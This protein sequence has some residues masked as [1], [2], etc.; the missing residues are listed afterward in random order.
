MIRITPEPGWTAGPYELYASSAQVKKEWDDLVATR[1]ND[2]KRCFERLTSAPLDRYPGRQF[3]LRGSS[4]PFWE[5]ELNGGDRVF[6][7]VKER[8]IVIAA[9][10]HVKEDVGGATDTLIKGRRK[11]FDDFAKIND[12]GAITSTQPPPSE[13]PTKPKKKK[14]RPK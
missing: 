1:P 11:G 6:Y 7:G 12:T 5:Y 3:P 9:G 4:K 2:A 13:K 10:D 8:A 14:R